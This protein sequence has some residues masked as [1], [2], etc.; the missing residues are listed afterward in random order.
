[1][2]AYVKGNSLRHL[3]WEHEDK[4]TILG[5]VDGNS[6]KVYNLDKNK[7]EIVKENQIVI[8]ENKPKQIGYKIGNAIIVEEQLP[9]AFLDMFKKDFDGDKQ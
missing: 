4:L 9:K 6:C 8:L 1:M 7:M 5:Y 2:D 3:G